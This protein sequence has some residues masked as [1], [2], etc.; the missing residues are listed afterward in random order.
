VH[1]TRFWYYQL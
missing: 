1:K